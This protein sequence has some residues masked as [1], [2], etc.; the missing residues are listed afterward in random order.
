MALFKELLVGALSG[1]VGANV[2]SHNK[3]GKY[4]R[5]LSIPTNP[6]TTFQSTVR[7]AFAS[8]T[9]KWFNLLTPSQRSAWEVYATNVRVTN[10]IGEQ[11]TLSGLSMFVRNQ[12]ARVAAGQEAVLDGPTDFTNGLFLFSGPD[13]ATEAAQTVDFQFNSDPG[14]SPWSGEVGSFLLCYL[15]RPQNASINYF[16]GPYR[17][18]G[19]QQ[20]DPVPPV[21][22]LTVNAPF[23]FVA[24]QKLFWRQVVTQID[25]RITQDIRG[26][27]TAIA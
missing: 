10:R 6:G 7:D 9:D 17:F 20:G 12:T 14:L 8:L 25:G 3:G 21:S 19:L 22:P 11:I 4:V 2:F 1:K 26:F 27:V 16:K 13:N 18:S 15:S 23:P 5:V 24:G